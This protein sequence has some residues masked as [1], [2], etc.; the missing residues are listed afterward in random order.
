MHSDSGIGCCN[1]GDWFTGSACNSASVTIFSLP[2]LAIDVELS[3][4]LVLMK[5]LHLWA[6][7]NTRSAVLWFVHSGGFTVWSRENHTATSNDVV[8]PVHSGDAKCVG[9]KIVLQTSCS[10]SVLGC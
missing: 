8:P 4:R 1:D 7:I 2:G 9:T 5:V 10:I 3:V 6:V